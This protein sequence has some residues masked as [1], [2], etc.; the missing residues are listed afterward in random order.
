M[1][2]D[3]GNL[4]TSNAAIQQGIG[5]LHR[6]MQSVVQQQAAQGT[7]LDAVVE[8]M[9]ALAEGVEHVTQTVQQSRMETGSSLQKL[10]AMVQRA[11]EAAAGPALQAA[12]ALPSARSP[13]DTEERGRPVKQQRR[14]AAAT[15]GA[16]LEA[17]MEAAS[18]IEAGDSAG[19][20]GKENGGG[21]EEAAAARAGAEVRRTYPAFSAQ[22]ADHTSHLTAGSRCGTPSPRLPLPSQA[23]CLT[24]R[25]S[26]LAPSQ[27]LL[28]PPP[29]HTGTPTLTGTPT[30]YRYPHHA[31][32]ADR[33]VR[34]TPPGSA[35]QAGACPSPTCGDDGNQGQTA[36][37]RDRGLRHG[38][39]ACLTAP[40]QLPVGAQD[41]VS[42]CRL[43]LAAAAA[44]AL[45][46]GALHPARCSG[47]SRVCA[48][49]VASQRW[50]TVRGPTTWARCGGRPASRRP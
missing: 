15:A 40:M 48:A 34:G 39:R 1:A 22:Q 50:S 45:P 37:S 2:T 8:G 47:A 4:V 16:S 30:T 28:T 11:R 12:A 41:S 31:G 25:T 42:C 6:G 13:P 49:D 18:A 14:T 36:G 24:A 26:T 10:V 46:G 35:A 44:A 29:P 17:A 3:L 21:Q 33:G 38:T 5:V 27:P 9:I 20:Q 7:I 23:S 43:G 19:V 32:H